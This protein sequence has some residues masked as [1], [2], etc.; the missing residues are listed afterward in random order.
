MSETKPILVDS[1]HKNSME[2]LKVHLQEWRGNPYV[3]L[4]V[5]ILEKPGE[6]ESEQPSRKGLT[7]SAELLPRLIQSLQK[8]QEDLEKMHAMHSERSLE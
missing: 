7:I 4:R 5:W 3:D 6:N 8:A 2:I 1:F